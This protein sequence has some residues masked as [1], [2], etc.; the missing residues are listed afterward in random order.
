MNSLKGVLELYYDIDRFG[1][2]I[3]SIDSRYY[4]SSDRNNNYLNIFDY[5]KA[6]TLGMIP[7]NEVYKAAFEYFSLSYTLSI[8]YTF[9]GKLFPYQEKLKLHII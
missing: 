7:K 3:I 1:L 2:N 8:V 5:I 9:V 4:Y 6:Y